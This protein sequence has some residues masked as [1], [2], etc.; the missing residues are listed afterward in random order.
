MKPLVSVVIASYNHQDYVEKA[1]K[2]IVEQDYQP[3]ELIVIDDGSTDG[4]A[5]LL[6]TLEARYGFCLIFKENGGVVSVINRAIREAKGDYLVVHA[7]D[8]E[9][10]PHRISNQVEILERYPNA[11][12]VSSNL[13]FIDQSGRYI[14]RLREITEK[15]YERGFADLFVQRAR[16]D[17]V[18]CMYRTSAL[19]KIGSINEMYS[20]EDPQIFFSLTYLGYSC[21]ESTGSPVVAYRLLPKSQS[22]LI[23]PRL[24]REKA[25]LI[26]EFSDHPL[27]QKAKARHK[28]T[29]ISALAEINKKEAMKELERGGY[30]FF[31]LGFLRLLI[32]LMLPS[33]WHG[34]FKRA[35]SA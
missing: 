34:Y 15:E 6:V 31:S 5:N 3:I 21:I 33:S 9:S 35:G 1:I 17:S 24:L 29:L 18:A 28:V 11:A 32:K 7:S 30:E 16:V 26:D 13:E 20:A 10:L 8:D 27:Y 25:R 4:S 14:A 19:R 23:L 12:F 22:R 2:S